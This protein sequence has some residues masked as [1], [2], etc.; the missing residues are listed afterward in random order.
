M[1]KGSIAA[2]K[3]EGEFLKGLGIVLGNYSETE[4][5]F[6]DCLVSEEAMAKLDE[7]WGDFF[8]SLHPMDVLH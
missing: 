4:N 7:H 5:E 8:W 2:T 6:Q 3:E 1:L